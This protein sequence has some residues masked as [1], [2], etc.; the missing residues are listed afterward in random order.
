[1]N[2]GFLQV[3]LASRKIP[4][5]FSTLCNQDPTF[6]ARHLAAPGNPTLKAVGR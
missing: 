2:V 1:M 5:S 4:G 6:S 3:E